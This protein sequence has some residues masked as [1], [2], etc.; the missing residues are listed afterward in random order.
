MNNP[1]SQ[2]I[3]EA[4]ANSSDTLSASQYNL[5]I[6]ATLVWGFGLNWLMVSKIPP[7]AVLQYG[8]LPFILAYF[9]CC[10]GGIYICRRS[11][12]PALS[13]LG[14]NMIV[15]PFGFIVNLVVSRYSSTLVLEAIKV[16][17]ATTGL[18]MFAGAAYPKFFQK[19]AGA[20]T[21]ALLAVIIVQLFQAFVFHTNPGI[22]DWIVAIIFCGYIGYDWSIANQQ[23]KT[24]DNAIDGAAALYM[25]I[26]NLFLRVLSILGDRR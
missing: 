14:Y 7:L 11:Q 2:S 8:F 15:V 22:M 21:L 23:T 9:A 4:T 13:F 6:G 5:A 10:F 16:T 26:I 25:D 17:G 3:T 20:L 19:I 12:N 24:L 1:Y 18:M